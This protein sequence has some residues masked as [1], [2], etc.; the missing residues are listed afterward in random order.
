[1]FTPPESASLN[2]GSIFVL[3]LTFRGLLA[4]IFDR[5]T[6]GAPDGYTRGD[7]SGLYA[8]CAA[9]V[10]IAPFAY[11][12]APKFADHLTGADVLP[13]GVPAIIAYGLAAVSVL[14]AIFGLYVN[15]GAKTVRS[16]VH[17]AVGALAGC[18]A[19]AVL[20]AA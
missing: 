2:V 1:M 10:V 7:R 6:K 11:W 8:A 17:T 5:T 14:N 18:L 15:D 13:D 20:V 9:V 4:P 3:V 19:A 12:V 16:I